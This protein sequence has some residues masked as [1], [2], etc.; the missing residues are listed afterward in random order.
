VGAG[1]H[2]RHIEV[3]REHRGP[4]AARLQ[5]QRPRTAQ[6][7][8]TAHCARRKGRTDCIAS[9]RTTGCRRVAVEARALY[10]AGTRSGRQARSLRYGVTINSNNKS[11]HHAQPCPQAASRKARPT[12]CR[13]RRGPRA[14]G[15]VEA[16]VCVC[17]ALCATHFRPRPMPHATS[18]LLSPLSC[19]ALGG[20][21]GLGL[22]LGVEARGQR[23]CPL[24][25]RAPYK[26]QAVESQSI[27]C[28][29]KTEPSSWT[30]AAAKK[31]TL[32]AP[33]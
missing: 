14:G 31:N 23:A 13:G 8:C 3:R 32:R 12:P 28:Q 1:S 21:W 11:Q 22:W 33:D 2:R 26:R 18:P 19:W 30:T 4:I 6:R 29:I 10:S 25:E 16:C 15:G 7:P 20:G 9:V 5:A 24:F 27:I 17:H